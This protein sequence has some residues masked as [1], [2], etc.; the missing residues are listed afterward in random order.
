MRIILTI[1]GIN[2]PRYT[3]DEIRSALNEGPYNREATNPHYHDLH[4]KLE[5]IRQSMGHSQIDVE[6]DLTRDECCSKLTVEELIEL[7]KRFCLFEA[8]KVENFTWTK[9]GLIDYLNR[10]LALV[11]YQGNLDF[12]RALQVKANEFTAN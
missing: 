9:A 5:A 6:Y 7:G 2:P 3:P 10:K 4:F 11:N 12:Y 8:L 1:E